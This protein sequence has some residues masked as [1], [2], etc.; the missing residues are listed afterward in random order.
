M[1]IRPVLCPH[2]TQIY[3]SKP[4]SYRDLP[5]RYME[6]EKMYRAEKPGEISGLNRVY[7]ITIEDGHVFCRIDQIKEEIKNLVKIVQ[8]FYKPL[9]IWDKHWVSLSVRDYEHPEK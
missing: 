4:R 7:S 1:V 6:S 3:A 8:D 2:Q 5:I 9:G